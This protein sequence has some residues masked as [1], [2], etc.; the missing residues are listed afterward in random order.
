MAIKSTDNPSSRY[1]AGGITTYIPS[2]RL[3]WWERQILKKR[4]DDIR[5]VV[6][7]RHVNRPDLISYD[8][9]KTTKYTWL[10]LQYNNI[11]NIQK[12]LVEGA[13]LVLPSPERV[14]FEFV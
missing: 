12:E 11:I 3:G 6:T 7:A 1:S 13:E 4:N 5:V 2:G 8:V 9:Y 10:V 14:V